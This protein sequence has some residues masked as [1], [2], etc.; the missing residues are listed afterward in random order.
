MP[1]MADGLHKG[2]IA[3]QAALNKCHPALSQRTPRVPNVEAT[4]TP[5][6]KKEAYALRVTLSSSELVE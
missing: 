3:L 6:S 4:H 5:A 2:S 1:L